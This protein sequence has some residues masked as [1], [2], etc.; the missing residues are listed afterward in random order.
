LIFLINHKI[1]FVNLATIAVIIA[2][3]SALLIVF[4]AINFFIIIEHKFSFLTN[5]N[6]YQDSMMMDKIYFVYCAI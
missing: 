5:V 6:A 3:I 1:P 2:K 4:L